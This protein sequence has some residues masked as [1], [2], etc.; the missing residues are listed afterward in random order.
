MPEQSERPQRSSGGCCSD[1]ECATPFTERAELGQR[2]RVLL[3][4]AMLGSC[5]V[6]CAAALLLPVAGVSSAVASRL[7]WAAAVCAAAVLLGWVRTA[8]TTRRVPWRLAVGVVAVVVGVVWY[9]LV[10]A[11]VALVALAEHVLRPPDQRAGIARVG[12]AP[13]VA[14]QPG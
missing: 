1:P 14:G 7:E 6:L 11:L 8:M 9:P 13:T 5:A 4:R 2:R 3:R 12:S 10:P